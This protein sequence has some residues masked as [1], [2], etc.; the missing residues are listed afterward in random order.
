MR[1]AVAF[2]GNEKNNYRILE[3]SIGYWIE[4]GTSFHAGTY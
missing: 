3:I 1:S 4:Y 2:E